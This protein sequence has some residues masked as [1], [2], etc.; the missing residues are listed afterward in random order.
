MTTIAE[1]EQELRKQRKFAVRIAYNG[2]EKDFDVE[3][4]EQVTVL[5]KRAIA[6]FNITQNPHLLSLF[7]ENGSLVPENESVEQAG[8]RPDE[9]LILRPNVVKGGGLLRIAADLLQ[10]TFVTLRACGR[11]HA[12]CV[13]YWIGPASEN[14][15]LTLEHPLHTRSPF[16]YQVDD[17]WLL[18]FSMRLAKTKQSVKVQVHTHPG[19]AFHSVTDDEWPIVS[20]AGFL[21]L[22]IPEFANNAPSFAGAWVGRLQTDGTWQKISTPSEAFHTI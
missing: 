8:L 12:E 7:R 13:V 22:V 5:L 1:N 21:S 10:E 11:N 6:G 17:Q 15:A 19:E 18:D 4:T 14:S 9:E 16:G 20:Q 2:V 3:P